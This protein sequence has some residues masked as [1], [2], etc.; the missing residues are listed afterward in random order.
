[1][2]RSL[3]LLALLV[4]T[5]P[6]TAAEKP[7]WCQKLPRPAYAKLE[8]VN[9]KSDWFEV[10]RVAPGIFAIYEPHQW[11][12]VISYLIVGQ[13]RAILF[14]TGMGIA[15]IKAV[16]EEL[17]KLPVM[18]LNSHTHNDHV[19]DNWRFDDVR[20]MNLAY[21][22]KNARGSKADAQQEIEPGAICGELP[23]GFDAK[24]YATKPWKIRGSARDG[25]SYDLGERTIE[26]LSTPGHT[27]DSISLLDRANGLLFTGDMFYLGPIFL[28]VP[29]TDWA[30]YK[31]SVQR[32]ESLRPQLKLLLPQHNTPVAS[33]DY[34]PKLLAVIDA[35]EKGTARPKAIE[36]GRVEYFFDDFSIKMMPLKR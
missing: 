19:G 9:V 6:A 30:A 32:W 29:E 2:L 26:V 25:S 20:G 22:R 13:K 35:I 31:R 8:R 3:A 17:T 34:I 14:D 1:M 4:T 15:N 23:A 12:E 28:Y 36:K 21:T 33:P 7:E 24:S 11:E 5:L 10:Y 18:V 16:V 27:P